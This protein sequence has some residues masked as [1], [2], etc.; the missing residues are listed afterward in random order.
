MLLTNNTA[1]T[2]L[3][4]GPLGI[5]VEPGQS[6][7]VTDAQFEQLQAHPVIAGWIAEGKLGVEREAT[8]DTE[9]AAEAQ[10]LAE[11]ARLAAE[12][13]AKLPTPDVLVTPPKVPTP[14]AKK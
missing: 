12:E 9:A 1:Q 14:T 3:G 10:R 6:V 2:P 11:A 7:T 5:T 4:F 13:A 8:E